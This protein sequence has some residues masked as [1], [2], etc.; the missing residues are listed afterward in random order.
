M[1]KLIST[2]RGSGYIKWETGMVTSLFCSLYI[3]LN[4]ANGN[5]Y[6]SLL[7]ASETIILMTVGVLTSYKTVTHFKEDKCRVVI[8]GGKERKNC[9]VYWR[10]D[11]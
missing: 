11:G 1:F 10:N 6:N 5:I 4:L 7:S 9:H 3:Y 8:A 2:G